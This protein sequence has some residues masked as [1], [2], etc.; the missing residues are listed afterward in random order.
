[1]VLD[2]AADRDHLPERLYP[3]CGCGRR[4]LLTRN[5]LLMAATAFNGHAQ[6]SISPGGL[7]AE[8]M[9]G[10]AG[11]LACR[12]DIE[13]LMPAGHRARL[14]PQ[15]L[16]GRVLAWDGE[17]NVATLDLGARHGLFVGLRLYH[18]ARGWVLV[19]QQVAAERSQARAEGG[20]VAEPAT[21]GT[22]VGTDWRRR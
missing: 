9:P 3:A 13:G 19:V 21:A 22:T 20:A 15:P 1:M 7:L 16:E 18:G 10:D 17:R 5:D 11:E 12:P 14:L 4:L 6:R 2:P 8:R